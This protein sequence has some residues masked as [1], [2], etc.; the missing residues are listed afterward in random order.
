M[1][2][3][4]LTWKVDKQIPAPCPDY[5]PDPYTGEYPSFHCAVYHFQNI[6]EEKSRYFKSEEEA[7]EFAQKAP[8]SCYEFKTDGK[9]IE[10]KRKRPENIT[11]SDLE[12]IVAF[13]DSGTTTVNINIEED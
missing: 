2:E 1:K 4:I 5:V 11:F 8:L 12:G 10:D 13:G 6:T 9:E 3:T 7:K